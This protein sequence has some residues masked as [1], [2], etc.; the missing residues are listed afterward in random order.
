MD[1]SKPRSKKA[2]I[3]RTLLVFFFIYGSTSYSLSIFE[4]TYFNLTG[5]ALFGVSKTIDSI[6]KDELISEF[7]RC[8]GPLLAANSVETEK[9]VSYTHLTLPTIYS[10]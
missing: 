2:Q 7:H 5:Q 9:A 8:G 6:T 4:Y 10:V 3:V 1:I